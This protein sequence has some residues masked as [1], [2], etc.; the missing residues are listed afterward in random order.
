MFTP[1]A[2]ECA[3]RAER[4]RRFGSRRRARRYESGVPRKLSGLPP[5]SILETDKAFGVKI[6]SEK[7]HQAFR[8]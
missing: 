7:L 6:L 8:D 2:M 5:H 4:R 1:L 3:D